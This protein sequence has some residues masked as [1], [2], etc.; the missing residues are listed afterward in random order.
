M[1]ARL[2]LR[3]L[4]TFGAR[5]DGVPLQRLRCAEVHALLA[6]LGVGEVR[7]HLRQG[8]ATPL[9]DE[10]QGGLARSARWRWSSLWA[11][12][13]MFPC[14]GCSFW[15]WRRPDLSRSR[16]LCP[17]W[18]PMST[19]LMEAWTAQTCPLVFPLYESA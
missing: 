12:S 19:I 2:Q 10:C 11:T 1:H 3:L 9:F 16:C 17:S 13:Q 6:Y 14:R 4:G 7:V 18:C 15:A 5:L 8:L